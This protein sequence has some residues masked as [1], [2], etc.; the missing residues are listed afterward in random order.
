MDKKERLNEAYEYLKVIGRVEK[1]QDVAN[2]IGSVKAY[3]SRAL[4]G[5]AEALTD[6]FLRRFANAY[7]DVINRRWLL[8]GEGN[9]LVDED[10][11]EVEAQTKRVR[12]ADY[13]AEPTKESCDSI[14]LIPISAM[15]GSLT[16]DN[17]GI[18]A[19]ECEHYIVPIF[20]GADFLIRVQ[21]DSML[22]KYQPG[23]IVACKRVPLDNIWF[24]WGKTYVADTCQGALIKRVERSDTNGCITF[25]SE[26]PI[27][28]PF[29]LP[30]TEIYALAL[31]VGSIRVE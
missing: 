30:T 5:H 25:H 9:M 12:R 6:S 11:Q 24:Q 21:G 14:P 18:L 20:R 3:V 23:D 15:A 4:G 7:C 29:D 28:A 8:T 26:N 31:V 16:G 1:Q 2:D 19:Y 22:P 10:I 17:D 13:L 27:Y